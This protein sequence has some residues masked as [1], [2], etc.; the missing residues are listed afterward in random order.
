[1]LA[2][3]GVTYWIIC[4]CRHILFGRKVLHKIGSTFRPS[5][6]INIGVDMG[7]AFSVLLFC[8]AMDPWYHHVNR[9][10]D[11]IVNKGYMDDNAT[12]GIGLSWIYAAETLLQSMATAGFLVLSHSC[13]Q[14]E[15]VHIPEPPSPIFSSMEFVTQGHHSLFAALGDS[16]LAPVVRL[17]CGN[18]AVTLSSNL[19][20]IGDT[21]QCPSHPF[22]LS[23]LHTA[24]CKCKCKTF[25]LS[26]SVLSPQQLEFL[27]S[28]PFGVKIVKPNATMLGLHLHSPLHAVTP[29]FSLQGDLLSPL[30]HVARAHIE[31]AQLNTAVSRMNQRV[32]AGTNLGLSFRERTLFLSF[33][34]LSL[35]HYHHSTLLPSSHYV[36]NYYRL[37]RQHLCKRAWIQAKHLPGVVT[38]LKL[39]ILH[40]P[41]IFLLSSMLGLCIRLYGLDIVLW[42]CGLTPYLPRLPKRLMEG[43]DS[44]RSE[45]VTADSFNKEPFSQQLHRFVADC[46][47]PYQLSRLVTRTFKAHVLQMLHADTRSFLRLR[48]SQVDWLGDSSSTTLDTL[49]ATPIKVIP[50]FAR[51][52]IL[53]WSI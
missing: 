11:I 25:L 22:L 32:K 43:L 7:R 47:P 51:L 41:K 42:L 37:I 18:R 6:P 26:N 16:P 14:V 13:Y 1:M 5:L 20:L 19:L 44:I 23:Y 49:H 17:R 9:I 36:A 52:A 48:I 8:I 3:R 27:D 40:C 50:P 30:P 29:R 33:Y 34:V 24:E 35:P 21:V 15:S 46:P 2:A 39:G 10:P 45:T 31:K 4:Y 53:R 28:T 12:G 38:Y